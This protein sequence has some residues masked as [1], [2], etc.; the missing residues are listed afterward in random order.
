MATA[1]LPAVLPKLPCG[2]SAAAVPLW[3]QHSGIGGGIFLQPLIFYEK[4][5]GGVTLSGG[6][7]LMQS[8]FAAATTPPRTPF[9]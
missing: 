4:S 8:T 2:G 9:A 1:Y 3:V 7:P 6:E 5:G